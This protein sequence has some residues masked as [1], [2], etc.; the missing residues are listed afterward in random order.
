MTEWP[1]ERVRPYKQD[2]I[3]EPRRVYLHL[4]CNNEQRAEDEWVLDKQLSQ[5]T[6]NS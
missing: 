5:L 6:K 3:Q 2:V 4:Y 1:Y